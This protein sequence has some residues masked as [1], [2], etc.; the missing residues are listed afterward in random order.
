[1]SQQCQHVLYVLYLYQEFTV[2][3]TQ[4]TFVVICGSKVLNECWVKPLGSIIAAPLEESHE[5]NTQGLEEI[6]TDEKEA[7]KLLESET[8]DASVIDKQNS[9]GNEVV[10]LSEKG[11]TGEV[12]QSETDNVEYRMVCQCG[13]NNCRKFV[14]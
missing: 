4:I 9:E 12:A 13:A 14:F 6:A 5:E 8:G 3:C 11:A 7:S 10:T 1:M 2:Q